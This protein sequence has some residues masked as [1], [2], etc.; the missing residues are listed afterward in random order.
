MKKNYLID[1]VAYMRHL[2]EEHAKLRHTPREPHFFRGELEEFVNGL[3]SGVS[4]PCL[5][6]ESNEVEYEGSKSNLIKKRTT[7][8]IIVDSYE[9][10]GDFNETDEKMS[11]CEMIAEDILSRMMSDTDKPFRLAQIEGADG[12][13]ML[14]DTDRYVGYR[15]TLTM[16]EPNVCIVNNNAWV[17]EEEDE[18]IT[19]T[20]NEQG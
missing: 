6:T 2:A 15:V 18:P 12:N 5:V 1:Y 10:V 9:N 19:D 11:L 7:S 16:V 14:N 3:R 4:F 20:G 17:K 8:F 13:Y